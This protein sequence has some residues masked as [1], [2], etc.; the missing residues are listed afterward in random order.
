MWGLGLRVRSLV[1][2][3]PPPLTFCVAL[4]N[5]PP[6]LGLGFLVCPMGRGRRLQQKSTG[7]CVLIKVCSVPC[8]CWMF[9]KY[10]VTHQQRFSVGWVGVR[11]T[12]GWVEG[13]VY[14]ASQIAHLA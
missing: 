11:L 14:I 3:L 12:G 4:G 13:R 10:L 2:V 1:H 9:S 5:S 6:L 7:L 8:R